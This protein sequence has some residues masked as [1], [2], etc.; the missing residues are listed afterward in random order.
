MFPTTVLEE[1]LFGSSAIGIIPFSFGLARLSYL[2]WC[3]FP[4]AKLIEEEVFFKIPSC[5]PLLNQRVFKHFFV[6]FILSLPDCIF[7][8]TPGFKFVNTYFQVFLIFMYF[9]S[10]RYPQRIWLKLFCTVDGHNQGF[11][12]RPRRQ[13]PFTENLFFSRWDFTKTYWLYP[14]NRIQ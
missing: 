2:T 7:S 11:W 4:S 8:I 9:L 6:F 14:V 3:S 5:D 1:K 12:N 10:R 13:I